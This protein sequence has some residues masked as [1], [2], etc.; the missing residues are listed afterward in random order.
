[1][2]D[3]LK[4]L[5]ENGTASVDAL[6][7]SITEGGLSE[8]MK[9]AA[10]GFGKQV[11][12]ATAHA[13]AL[14]DNM[15]AALSDETNH[16]KLQE[17]AEGITESVA[18]FFGNATDAIADGA[19]IFFGNLSTALTSAEARER[20]AADGYTIAKE[21]VVGMAKLAKFGSE[22]QSSVITP[23]IN[24]IVNPGEGEKSWK[25]VGNA[26]AA[27]IGDGVLESAPY[28]LD[29]VN[30][31]LE[32]SRSAVSSFMEGFNELMTIPE[33][34]MREIDKQFGLGLFDDETTG[35]GGSSNE[36]AG[37]GR[38]TGGGSGTTTIIDSSKITTAT[39][40]SLKDGG[41]GRAVTVNQTIYSEAKTAAD[42]M[43]EARYE[44]EKAVL[45]DV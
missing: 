23:L 40:P 20:Y 45:F 41:S 19:V 1:M 18:T 27:G 16:A 3:P 8:G 12:D 31:A 22:L 11:T 42:L 44:A 9:T 14:F 28:I 32:T 5:A 2:V 4:W 21:I 17:S 34:R 15:S 39:Q 7:K 30:A 10:E 35:G 25:D 38:T 6:T 36:G 26:I 43:E 33:E 24:S 37:A 13:Q 29:A